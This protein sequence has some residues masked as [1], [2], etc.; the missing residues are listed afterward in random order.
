MY[1]WAITTSSDFSGLV[2]DLMVSHLEAQGQIYDCEELTIARYDSK[3]LE[4]KSC[5]T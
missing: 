1:F 3:W 2:Y 4:I 5:L